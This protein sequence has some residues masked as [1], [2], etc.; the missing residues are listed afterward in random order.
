M[1]KIVGIDLGTTNS[2][3]A[4]LDEVGK[5]KIVSNQDGATITPSVIYFDNENVVV[6]EEAKKA[7]QYDPTKCVRFVKREMQKDDP[8]IEI[9]GKSFSPEECSALI[10]KKICKDFEQLEGKIQEAVITVPANFNDAARNRTMA[11]AQIAGLNVQNIINEPTAAAL[12]YA[13]KSKLSGKLVVYDL[14]GGTFDV[15]ACEITDNDVRVL[16]S[17]GVQELGGHDFD[18]KLI[19]FFDK[20]LQEEHNLSLFEDDKQI[21]KIKYEYEIEQTK[22][23][24]SKRDKT[25]FTV[26]TK[27]G[28]KN[29]SITKN[30]FEDLISLYVSQT[31]LQLDSLCAELS[32]KPSDFS[33]VLLVGGSTRIPAF[34]ESVKKYFGKE[35]LT[36]VNV[37][38]AIA[39]GAAIYAGM[40]T[41]N[42]NLNAVQQKAVEAVK[43]QE[44]TNHYFGTIVVAMDSARN[45]P[46]EEVKIM[47]KKNTEIPCEVT[48]TVYTLYENQTEVEC[49]VTQDGFGSDNP[50]MVRKVKELTLGPL[51]ANRPQGQPIEVTYIYDSNQKM[52]CKFKDVNS[53]K[54]VEAE[55]FV[56]GT[57]KKEIES[58]K[59]ELEM[60]I[61]E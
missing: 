34:Y 20:K 47:I 49:T 38:E 17:F 50:K 27:E 29:L 30:E 40:K 54:E 42:S 43:L 2:A 18:E 57:S 14:G 7:T 4:C 46:K 60:F 16:S 45:T 56:E 44:V 32:L 23:T 35:P 3:I 33:N 37:D 13:G 6:G 22:K 19:E 11:A 12:F 28:P 36:E 15:T 31:E 1:S 26:S 55:I 10:L 52:S 41:E 58:S 53:N 24:L 51:P 21:D 59:D 61:L 39:L 48:D 8:K 9:N 25:I 5:P